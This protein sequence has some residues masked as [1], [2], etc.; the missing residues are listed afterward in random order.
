MAAALSA[1]QL[2]G[3]PSD[4]D[5]KFVDFAAIRAFIFVNGHR[6]TFESFSQQVDAGPN[7]T[8]LGLVLQMPLTQGR[9]GILPVF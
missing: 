8:T 1:N 6:S 4:A 2:I 9:T 3:I 5:Q 7:G